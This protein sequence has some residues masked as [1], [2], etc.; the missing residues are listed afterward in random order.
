MHSSFEFKEQM[1]HKWIDSNAR[2]KRLIVKYYIFR[3]AIFLKT[4]IPWFWEVV[5]SKISFILFGCQFV[6]LNWFGFN[7][8]NTSEKLLW[9]WFWL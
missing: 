5:W 1:N 9:Y 6:N 2:I 4:V 3:T 7:I 8:T